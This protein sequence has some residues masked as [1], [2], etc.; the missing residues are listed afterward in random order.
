[1]KSY[2]RLGLKIIGLLP[3]RPY[4]F[5]R[6]FVRFKRFPSLSEPERFTEKVQILKL[7]RTNLEIYHYADKFLVRE[8]VASTLN[9]NI[10][11]PL[12]YSTDKA[13][14]VKPCCLSAY[15]VIVKTSHDSSGG[16]I[17][18]SKIDKKWKVLHRA[19]REQLSHSHHIFGREPEYRNPQPRV[20]V[21]ALI[22]QSENKPLLTDYKVYCFHG[23]PKYIQVLDNRA[24]EISESWF[25][26]T[27]KQLEVFYFSS[28]K[29]NI[30]KP[31]CLS[32]ML[33]VAAALSNKFKFVRVDLYEKDGNVFFGELTLH[34]YSGFMKWQPDAF[35]H[36]L[37][38]LLD[39][40]DHERI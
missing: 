23:Q 22:S 7:S 14:E 37:G 16:I 30:D 40:H 3:A 31:K 8:Y 1:M 18:R 6:Y 35:D 4:L 36:H 38:A 34:P 29:T 15:P 11:I 13:E 20:I 39:L 9:E 28:R 5:V 25:D 24:Q 33:Q 2:K 26:T 32:K 17:L 10:L 19:L 21:E 12:L 27:W